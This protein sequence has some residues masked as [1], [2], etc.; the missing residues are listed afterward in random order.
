VS[1]VAVRT[2]TA[3]DGTRLAYREAGAG[4]PVVCLPGGPMQDPRYLADLGGLTQRARLL[5]L[6]LRGT[7]SSSTPTDSTSYRCERMVD[8]VE[9]LRTDLQVERISVLGHSAGAQ[10]AVRYALRYPERVHRLVLITPGLAS[11]GI[12]VSNSDRRRVTDLRRGE[13]W[14]AAASTALDD[15][16]A[17]RITAD[18]ETAIAPFFYGTWNATTRVH[19]AA[20]ESQ[21]N[22]VA[23]EV[24]ADAARSEAGNLRAALPHLGMPTLVLAGELDVNTPPNCAATLAGLIPAAEILIQP[25]AAH[26]PWLDNPG[27]FTDHVDRFLRQ[28]TIQ[29]T[30]P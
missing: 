27:E 5:L 2:F 20:A 22:H 19:Q 28:P 3:P 29:P 9:A 15:L 11:L 13:S 16:A 10:L 1:T 21:T 25:G 7:G 26:Y 30:Q 18:T 12:E 8:D 23:A 24:F 17:G 14:F 4:T 6:E